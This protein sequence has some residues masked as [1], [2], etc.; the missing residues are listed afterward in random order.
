MGLTRSREG[1]GGDYKWR[2][3]CWSRQTT[4]H[5]QLD[6]GLTRSREKS[7]GD[8]EWGIECWS[9]Q[10]TGRLRLGEGSTRSQWWNEA[11]ARGVRG[12]WS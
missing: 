2:I 12:C 10:T 8:Y 6:V 7:G 4:G 9:R 3:E 1:S 5:L 11:A